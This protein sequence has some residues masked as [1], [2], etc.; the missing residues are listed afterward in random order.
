M[1][2]KIKLDI[3]DGWLRPLLVEDVHEGYVQGLNDPDVNRFLIGP[4]LHRQTYE[5]VT[6][7]VRQNLQMPDSIL[8]GI[9]MK[10]SEKHCGTIR[11]YDID[12]NKKSANIG[13]CI[14]DKDA[15]GR[16]L[17]SKAIRAVTE[18]GMES[19]L[20]L[21]NIEAGA[22]IENQSSI[23]AFLAAGYRWVCDV[24]AKFPIEGLS[25]KA[26]ILVA[27]ASSASPVP[28]ASEGAA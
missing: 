16:G 15:W 2:S 12:L 21:H 5:S 14:F 26:S 24:P 25:G 8:F 11:L 27:H 17:G 3:K 23:K 19:E 1:L 4:R 13:I 9:W 18:W 22:Y 20:K 6:D 10:N 28:G 7:F